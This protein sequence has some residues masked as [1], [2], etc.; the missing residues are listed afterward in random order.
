MA[1]AFFWLPMLLQGPPAH[2]VW[3]PKYTVNPAIEAQG[4]IRYSRDS[5]AVTMIQAPQAYIDTVSAEPDALFFTDNIN[6]L[7]NIGGQAS[8]AVRNALEAVNVPGTWVSANDSWRETIRII[9]GMFY[10]TQR[11]EG[12]NDSGFFADLDAAGFGLNTQWQNL[13]QAFRDTISANIA[14]HGWPDVPANNS[15]VRTILRDFA[16]KYETWPVIIGGV[17]V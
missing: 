11:H 13:S 2:Q 7:D 16:D 5:V 3:R 14:D 9:A 17:T 10:F 1:Q 8:V 6:I 15:Q 4:S 12:L